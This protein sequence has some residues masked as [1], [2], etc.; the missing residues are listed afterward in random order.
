MST[1]FFIMLCVR[2]TGVHKSTKVTHVCLIFCP[3]TCFCVC[4]SVGLI[5]MSCPHLHGY[6]LGLL[7]YPPRRIQPSHRHHTALQTKPW[8]DYTLSYLLLWINPHVG[9]NIMYFLQSSKAQRNITYGSIAYMKPTK[10]I[11]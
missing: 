3:A 1:F 10:W 4:V 8:P 11:D 7:K 5:K 9:Y 2:N 6:V